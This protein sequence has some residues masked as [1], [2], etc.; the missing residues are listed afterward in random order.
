[1]NRRSALKMGAAFSSLAA[2]SPLSLVGRAVAN[3]ETD[4]GKVKVTGVKTA[5][6]R[7]G[8]YD[9]QLVKVETNSGIYG[10]GETYPQTAGA[11]QNLEFIKKAVIGQDPLQVEYLF[12]KM[13]ALGNS[14]GKR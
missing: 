7:L 3:A 4:L 2:L 6:F 9:T 13:L 8:K 11:L 14:N 10:L 5:S 12:Y 1:M